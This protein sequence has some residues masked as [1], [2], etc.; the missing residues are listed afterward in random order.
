MKK[1]IR[2]SPVSYG[3]KAKLQTSFGKTH[4]LVVI[5]VL[6]LLVIHHDSYNN[7][8]T[9]PQVMIGEK[10]RTNVGTLLNHTSKAIVVLLIF[11]NKPKGGGDLWY[12]QM[13]SN[14]F[15]PL[16]L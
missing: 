6:S 15:T 2:L 16:T 4:K 10:H 3:S 13:V 8:A 7:A 1:N 9:V 12:I 14:S 11:P 5:V